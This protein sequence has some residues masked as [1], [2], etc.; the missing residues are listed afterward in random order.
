MPQKPCWLLSVGSRTD[1]TDAKVNKLMIGSTPKNESSA[2]W[3][4]R[5]KVRTEAQNKSIPFSAFGPRSSVVSVL[6]SL[7][8]DRWSTGSP[9]LNNFF[10]GE[11]PLWL[12]ATEA[13]K[14]LPCVALLL[15]LDAPH[16][17]LV[18][19]LLSWTLSASVGNTRVFVMLGL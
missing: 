3:R 16:P 18:W 10:K 2:E 19:F 1:S 17:N 12:L 8:S 6:M 11:G 9:L 5:N 13:F 7:I 4:L 14:R 15:K